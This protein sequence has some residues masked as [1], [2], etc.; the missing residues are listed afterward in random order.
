MIWPGDEVPS[1]LAKAGFKKKKEVCHDNTEKVESVIHESFI[2]GSFLDGPSHF[3]LPGGSP[4]FY[5]NIYRRRH[6]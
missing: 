6:F 1:V 5:G 2:S 4:T 3:R